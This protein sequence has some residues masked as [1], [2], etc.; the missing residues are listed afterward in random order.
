MDVQTDF[1][2]K[3]LLMMAAENG[4]YELASMCS[5]VIFQYP[6][7]FGVNVIYSFVLCIQSTSEQIST[8]SLAV[9]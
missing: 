2:Q 8:I 6:F 4:L 9:C 5:L 7:P 1:S 3:T